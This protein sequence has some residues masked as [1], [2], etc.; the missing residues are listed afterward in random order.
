MTNKSPLLYKILKP[1]LGIIYKLWYNPKIIGKENIPKE[2]PII[3]VGNH[4]H[5]MDQ[6]NL[7]I[8]TKRC[9]HYLAKKEYFD[10]TYKEGKFS[11]FFK[12]TGCIP[13]DRSKKDENAT[14]CAL[15]VLQA[16]E[17]LGLFPEG[18]RNCLKESTIKELYQ[19]YYKGK[20]DYHAFFKKIHN[21]KT[22]LINYFEELNN[23]K[24]ITKKEFFDNIYTV[25]TF[26]KKLIF[27]KRI[28]KEEYYHNVLLPLKFGA[29]S[30]AKKTNS[31]IIPFA[32]TGEYK[33]RSKNL[34]V[35]IG[36]PQKP[37]ENLEEA[38]K[39]LTQTI[40]NLIKENENISGK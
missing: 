29:V 35:R 10:K 14:K 36:K 18:T 28:T 21:N 31:L 4:I 32:I 38:N 7:I 13:V 6:C 16:S 25:E 2:G 30:M 20:I 22:S 15:E 12:K 34:I 40:T 9:I 1:T 17:A 24:V 5:L 37:K 8:S 11:W 19:K 39:E 23:K 33:F 3:I 26:L 27:E